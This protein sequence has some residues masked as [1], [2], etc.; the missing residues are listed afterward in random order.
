MKIIGEIF[1]FIFNR[2]L[3]NTDNNILDRIYSHNETKRLKQSLDENGSVIPWFTYPAIEYLEQFD[4]SGKSVFEWGSG[5][6]SF[7][8]SKRCETIISIE[9]NLDWYNHVNEKKESNQEI[10]YV[11]I[12]DYPYVIK[13][14]D[15]KFDIIIVDGQRRFDC[16]KE[17]IPFLKEGGMIILDNSDW[18]YISAAF[19]REHLNLLQ[20]DFHGFG[21]GNDYPWTTSFLISRNFNYP[22]IG[23]RQPVNPKGGLLLHDEREIL[24]REDNL[25]KTDNSLWINSHV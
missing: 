18:F 11:P 5:N 1:K 22:L 24:T 2:K 23:N 8:F 20:V 7:F 6:S 3:I 16:A 17:C 25:F 19:L 9:H 12:S 10:R 4:L 13:E 21:P 15:R 14:F